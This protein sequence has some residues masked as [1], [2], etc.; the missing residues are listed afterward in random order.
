MLKQSKHAFGV[1]A[2]VVSAL[3]LSLSDSGA[4][5]GRPCEE[6]NVNEAAGSIHD[7]LLVNGSAGGQNRMVSV[8]LGSPF[9]VALNE[10]PGGSGQGTYVLWLWLGSDRNPTTLNA[11]GGEVGCLVNPTPLDS[12]LMPQP[13][14]CIAGNGVPIVACQG[15]RSFSSPSF[16]PWVVQTR[17]RSQLTVTMQGLIRDQTSP[18]PKSVSV[19]N[20][21]N[22]HLIV[23]IGTNAISAPLQA[24]EV[25]LLNQYV[26]LCTAVKNVRYHNF[27]S[28]TANHKCS[29]PFLRVL[30]WRNT[31]L[32]HTTK[33]LLII[34][35]LRAAAFNSMTCLITKGTYHVCPASVRGT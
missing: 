21:V 1:A 4:S 9:T 5:T 10:A 15:T 22:S 14:Y 3:I 32:H 20:A 27:H 26:T 23:S 28:S 18:H 29:P 2:V 35:P 25:R 33:R 6:G 34:F 11:G 13:L 12:G 24:N 16:A 17:Y 7:V 19:T 31:I 30:D 8:L